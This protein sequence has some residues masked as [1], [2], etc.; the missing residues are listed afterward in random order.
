MLKRKLALTALTVVLG[1]SPIARAADLS[2]I[3]TVVVIYAENRSF[4]NL[5]GGFPGANGL[6]DAKPEQFVQRDRDGTPLKGLPPIWGGTPAGVAKGAPEA[7]VPATQAQSEA[8]LGTFN[9]PY[10]VSALYGQVSKEATNPLRYANRDLYHRFYEN[11]MQING[12][13]NDMFAAWGDSGGMVMGYFAPQPEDLPLWGWAS[14]YVL[15]DN[16]FQGAFG[17]SFLNHFF[18]ICA[19]APRYPNHGVNP[20]EGGKNPPVSILEADGVTLKIAAKSPPSAMQG[21]PLFEASTNLTPDYY[22]VNTMQPPF[23]PSNNADPTQTTVDGKLATTLPP[24]TAQTIGDLLTAANVDWAWY[25]G[26]WGYAL[27]HKPHEDIDGTNV[28]RFQT[29]HQP[30]NYFEAFAPATPEGKANR[31][32]H[33]RDGG[34]GGTDFIAA[35]DAGKLPT[36][37]FYKPQGDLNEHA[38]YADVAKGDEHIADVLRH[39]E[40]SP[41]WDHMLVVV[42][43]D[44]NGGWWD[45]AAPPKAD[46]F[47]P[48]SRIPAMIISP[49]AKKGVVDH[50][51]YDTT[52]IIRFITHR[53]SLPTLPGVAMRDEAMAKAGGA[54]IGD[55]TDALVLQ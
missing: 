30:F 8:W 7:P 39:L 11:Q 35:I 14:R 53:W 32:K 51:L 23:P 13:K 27:S 26:A 29:H 40:K 36:V 1:A 28:P 3:Q 2:A 41:Q 12:G 45:H 18:L 34:M 31:E 47:G 16:F 37:T 4:D 52:S 38:G 22:A 21:K 5:Y 25:A 50:T 54:R 43:Y 6:A 10:P 46:R 33:L 19:C 44:E 17:G 55:L 20:V 15:A 48:G 24:Q 42:T 49:F 9:H